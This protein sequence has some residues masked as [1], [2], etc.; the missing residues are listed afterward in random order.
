MDVLCLDLEGGLVPEVWQAVARATEVDG[1]LKT[2][3]DIPVYEDLMNYRLE[4]LD[5]HNITLSDVQAQIAK[6]QPLPVGID[7]SHNTSLYAR[8]LAIASEVGRDRLLYASFT[9]R[10]DASSKD[11]SAALHATMRIGAERGKCK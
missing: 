1:L 7:A 5:E 8:A 6:L 11:R 9:L 10:A 2:T 4:L 3:R